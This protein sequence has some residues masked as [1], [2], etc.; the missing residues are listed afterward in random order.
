MTALAVSLP[1]AR[2]WETGQRKLPETKVPDLNPKWSSCS[3]V[4]KVEAGS[5][6]L[7]SQ[8]C[9]KIRSQQRQP[10]SPNEPRQWHEGESLESEG[11]SQR[12]AL[13]QLLEA[14]LCALRTTGTR[15]RSRLPATFRSLWQDFRGEREME[16]ASNASDTLVFILELNQSSR[17]LFL[18]L[19]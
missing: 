7:M 13:R 1:K 14:R 12:L 6:L 11:E 5:H 8:G 4:C 16:T 10:Q 2:P 17:A 9:T 3:C 19:A 18:G 15:K